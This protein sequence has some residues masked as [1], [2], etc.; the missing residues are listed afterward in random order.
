M[1]PPFLPQETDFSCAVACFRMVLAS[2]GITK[3]EDELRELC[4]CTIFGTAAIELVH[5][6]RTLGLAASRKYTLKL[7]DLREF[8]EQGYHPIVYV[9]AAAGVRPPEVHALLVVSVTEAEIGALDPKY[10]R[11]SLSVREFIE[12]WA[13][14]NNLA[15]VVARFA[16]E[17][18]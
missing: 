8:T 17:S 14:M 15:I 10:G 12:M 18:D 2:F 1:T 13:P 4:D 3:S 16:P 9:V 5:A 7:E 11:C 6:A